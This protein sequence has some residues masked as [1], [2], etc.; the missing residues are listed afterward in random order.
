MAF[1]I[2]I[3]PLAFFLG[4]RW[5]IFGFCLAWLTAFPLLFLII[6]HRSL[7]VMQLPMRAIWKTMVV[8]LTGS[9]VMGLVIFGLNILLAHRLPKS[10]LLSLLVTGGAAAYTLTVFACNREILKEMKAFALAP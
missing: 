2:V 6:C 3:M 10:V 8:P 1:A 5:G 9:L 7:G 4:A